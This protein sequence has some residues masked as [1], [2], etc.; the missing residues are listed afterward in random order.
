MVTPSRKMAKLTKRDCNDQ[1]PNAGRARF[2]IA[3][4]GTIFLDEIGDLPLELQV[5]LLRVLQEGEFERLGSNKTRRVDVR[6]LAATN[7]DLEEAMAAGRFRADLYYRLKVFPIEVPPLRARREDIPL[8]VWHFI[9][10]R[11]GQLR[12]TIES[13]PKGLMEAF[14]AYHWPGNVRELEN[15]VERALIVS[16]GPTLTLPDSLR[17]MT[18]A[19][20]PREAQAMQVPGSLQPE[21]PIELP[22]EEFERRHILQV[23]QNTGWRIKGK[24]GAAELLGLKPTTLNSRMKKLGIK[25]PTQPLR[26]D[27]PNGR[28]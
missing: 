17:E 16:P 28:A 14:Q 21:S 1:G 15:I 2:E 6:V 3:D 20:S 19:G 9:N 12:R 26:A 27:L 10:K 18:M 7:R 23:V 22:L 13:I 8:L 24:G 11:Q 5:K 4:G 25:R